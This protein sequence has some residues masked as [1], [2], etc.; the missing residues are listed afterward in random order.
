MLAGM[1]LKE[2]NGWRDYADVAG[3]LGQAGAEW[4]HAELC[5]VLAAIN[6]AKGMIHS[7]FTWKSPAE[8]VQAEVEREM[9]KKAKR[10]S[11]SWQHSEEHERL[12]KGGGR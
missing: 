2:F 4:R 6:G 7:D 5:V 10:E 9:V 3:P 12:R 8:L 11:W 1:S